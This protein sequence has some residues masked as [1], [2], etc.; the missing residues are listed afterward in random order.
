[1]K[2]FNQLE[3][4][5]NQLIAKAKKLDK[6]RGALR[7]TLFDEKLFSCRSRLLTPCVLEAKATYETI[8]REKQ[9]DTLSLALAEHLTEKLMNQISAISLELVA[10]KPFDLITNKLESIESLTSQLAQHKDWEN[11]LIKLVNE[12][13][14][15]YSIAEDKHAAELILNA[16]KERLSRCQQSKASIELQILERKK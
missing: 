9:S 10:L 4:H 15:S 1:M 7:K 2:Q 11:R 16:S 14:H 13:Q 12:K 3:V 8:V 6:Q 5:L